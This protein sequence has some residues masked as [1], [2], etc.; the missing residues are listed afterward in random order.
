MLVEHTPFG[1]TLSAG[2][3]YYTYII[4]KQICTM[5]LR[6]SSSPLLQLLYCLSRWMFGVSTRACK[7]GKRFGREQVSH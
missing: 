7:A 2:S 6:V 3:D 1:H 5:M 4:F